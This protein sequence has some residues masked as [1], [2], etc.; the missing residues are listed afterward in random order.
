[1]ISNE[2]NLNFIRRKT[3]SIWSE[4]YCI[5][6]GEK[7]KDP[8]MKHSP[9]RI[10]GNHFQVKISRNISLSGFSVIEIKNSTSNSRSIEK[11]DHWSLS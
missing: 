11:D 6:D 3:D 8:K 10:E 5:S 1:M 2:E 4:A 9:I 7:Q